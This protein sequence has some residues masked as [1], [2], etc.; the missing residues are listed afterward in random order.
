MD[1]VPIV[2][3]SQMKLWEWMSSYYMCSIGEVLKAG[4]PSGLK[5]ESETRIYLNNEYVAEERLSEVEEEFLDT[6]KQSG[7]HTVKEINTKLA[8]NNSYIILRS[9]IDKKA[10]T[11]EEEIH[12]LFKPKK[13]SFVL[14][15]DLYHD[16]NQLNEL[17]E[18]LKRAKV[19]LNLLMGF[20]HLSNFGNGKENREVSK[21]DLFEYTKASHQALKALIEKEVFFEELREVSRLDSFTE[22]ISVKEL[23]PSQSDA[24]KSIKNLFLTRNTVLLHGVTSSGKT[25][26]YIHLIQ[27]Y[28]EEGKQILYLLPEI[29]LT[30]QIVNRLRN[31]FGKK[32]GVYHSKFNDNE[33]IEVYNG[34]LKNASGEDSLQLVLGVRSSVFLPFSNLGLVIVDEEHENTY[35]QFDPAPRYHARDTAIY[36]ATLHGAKVLLGTATPSVESFYNA[37]KGKYGY[38]ELKERFQNMELPEVILADTREAYRKKEMK[39]IFT[40]VLLSN[41]E[42]A[43]KKDEQ[44]ILFKNRRGYAPYIE[45]DTCNWIPYCKNCDVTL[46]YHKKTGELNCHYCGYNIKVPSHCHV[47]NQPALKTKGFG[48]EKIEDE[49]SVFFPDANIQRMDLDSTRSKKAYEKIISAFE[50][51]E[52]DVLVGTQMISK[53]LDFDRVSLVGVLN[54]DQMLNFPDFRA[55]ER[56]YQLMAQVSGRAGR[57]N[58]RGKVIIQVSDIHHPVIDDVLHNNFKA[59]FLRQIDERKLFKYPPFY[60]LILLKVKHK[61]KMIVNKASYLLAKQLFQVFGN[62]VSGPEFP[63]I[64]RIQNMFQKNIMLKIEA[65]KSGIGVRQNITNIIQYVNSM[66]EYRS[67]RVVIDVDPQ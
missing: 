35:K 19:Q 6:L 36:L 30:T 20:I 32:V 8:I 17:F 41:I 11:T 62:R 29:A 52:I 44:V 16:D 27:Q 65:D 12:T 26:I 61:D 63:L 37:K 7:P 24:L 28:I 45:C 31:V 66:E 2:T 40:P 25:E 57:K 15:N 46:T 39:S 10:I 22:T 23:N 67:V 18:R 53:G 33:R 47:C 49:L 9:L 43:L 58:K 21:S 55:H 64:E 34:V 4:L 59:L 13:E 42:N 56:S 51:K 3:N 38:V 5:L 50:K 60:R 48:T 54:A 14:L 1:D